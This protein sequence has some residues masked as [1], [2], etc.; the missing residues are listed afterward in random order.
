MTSLLLEHITKRFPGVKALDAVTMSV[1]GGEIHA[2]CGENGAGKSTLMNVLVGNFQPDAGRILLNGKSITISPQQAFDHRIA[3]VY[4]HLSLIDSLS[5]AENIYAN[6]QPVNKFGL[7]QFG[8]LYKRTKTLLLQL[9]LGE[10]NPKTSVAKLSPAQKQ[11]VE[12]AKALSKE[13][14]I[15]I[16]DEPTASLTDRET[17]VLFK[18]LKNLRQ[19]GVAIIYISHRLDEIFQLADRITVLKDGKYQGTFSSADITKDTLIAKMVGRE[20][21]S[22]NT[23]SSKTEQVLLEVKNLSGTKFENISFKLFRG[24]VLGLAGLVGA[25]RTE[26]ARAI[27]G[28]DKTYGGEITFQGKRI[29]LSHPADAI[30]RNIAYV[31]EER[32]SQGL[33]P[34]MSIQDNVTVCRLNA[35]MQ[36]GIYNRATVNRL[37]ASSSERLGITTKNLGQRISNLSGGNQQKVM[38]AKWLLTEPEVLIVDEPT[39]GIDV[40]AKYEI[41]QILQSLAA[42]GKGIVMISSELPEL[43]GLCDRIIVIKTG[44]MSGELVGKD[45]SEEKVMML[46]T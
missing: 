44:K 30:Q 22:L 39:H 42:E 13:P 8:E 21:K 28:I 23:L 31:S 12:I 10:I 16:L 37:A 40:G 36:S 26:I 1:N 18:I 45:I 32:K 34:D 24:E 5:V 4:Q 20:I 6:Q 3:I 15:F 41:Y 38:L 33:F 2:L 46:A 43:I 35:G 19:N 29:K 11:M 27:F 25:G 9:S 7:I 14:S 17:K